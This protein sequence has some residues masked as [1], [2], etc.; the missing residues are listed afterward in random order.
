MNSLGKFLLLYSKMAAYPPAPPEPVIPR[1]EYPTTS[2]APLYIPYS[3][4][5]TRPSS[6][7][8]SWNEHLDNLKEVET[9]GDRS[10][11]GDKNKKGQYTA[12]GPYQ[13]HALAAREA[14]IRDIKGPLSADQ[15]ALRSRITAEGTQGATVRKLSNGITWE[16]RLMDPITARR[17]ALVYAMRNSISRKLVPA[18]TNI[19]LNTKH[20]DFRKIVLLHNKGPAVFNPKLVAKFTPEVNAALDKYWTKYQDAR[21]R[22]WEGTTDRAKFVPLNIFN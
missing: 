3:K 19:W 5:K 6:G 8:I 15:L 10:W 13:M 2:E 1:E 11:L 16:Q 20:P 21:K 4:S 17:A 12:F 7:Y 9:P 14:G 22:Q 18:D